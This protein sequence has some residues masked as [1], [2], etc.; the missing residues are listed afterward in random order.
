M[1][2]DCWT[3][4]QIC[5]GMVG[6]CS[7]LHYEGS[8]LGQAGIDNMRLD[9]PLEDNFIFSNENTNLDEPIS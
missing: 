7:S 3:C 6:I 5:L 4:S 1:C 9:G 8:R 2:R